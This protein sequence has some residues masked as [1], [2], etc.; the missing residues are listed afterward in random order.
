MTIIA[1]YRFCDLAGRERL[2]KV[3]FRTPPDKP[4]RMAM[5]SWSSTRDGWVKGICDEQYGFSLKA[6]Y[7]L[8][9]VVVALKRGEPVWLPEGEKDVDTLVSAGVP[10]T[11]SWQGAK[12]FEHD[13]ARWFVSSRSTVNLCVDN[14]LPGAWAGWLRY[15]ILTDVGVSAHR[16]KVWAAPVRLGIGSDVTDAVEA[17]LGLDGLRRVGLDRLRAAAEREAARHAAARYGSGLA[18][19]TPTTRGA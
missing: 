3:R 6:M 12:A 17:G 10:A 14:D 4:K 5:L 16:I 1:D 18:T 7:R 2:R 9:E 15:C 8:P 11:T 19:L 13:Q